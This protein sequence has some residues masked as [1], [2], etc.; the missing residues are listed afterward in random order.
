MCPHQ[1]WKQP[2]KGRLLR[3]PEACR[4]RTSGMEPPRTDRVKRGPA[5]EERRPEDP[6]LCRP[7]LARLIPVQ[8]PTLYSAAFRNYL[9]SVLFYRK[10]TQKVSFRRK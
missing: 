9:G 6:S 2:L 5:G 4:G 10:K 1:S 3:E 8:D 7:P